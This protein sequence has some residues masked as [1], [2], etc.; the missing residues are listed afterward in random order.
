MRVRQLRSVQCGAG[1]EGRHCGWRGIDTVFMVRESILTE[2]VS[3]PGEWGFS[4]LG[5]IFH[6]QDNEIVRVVSLEQW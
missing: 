4:E 5:K 6:R 3:S 2:P 1:E